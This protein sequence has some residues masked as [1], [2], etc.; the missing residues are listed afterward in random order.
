MLVSKSGKTH[1][2]LQ[3]TTRQQHVD[4]ELELVNCNFIAI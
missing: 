2:S 3:K 4:L 1:L